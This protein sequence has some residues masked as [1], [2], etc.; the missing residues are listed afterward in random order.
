MAA[1]RVGRANELAAA[2]SGPVV[3]LAAPAQIAAELDLERWLAKGMTAGDL[4]GFIDAYLARAIHLPHP[5]ALAHQVAVPNVG[6]AVADLVHGAINNPMAIY[7]MGPGAATVEL[8]VTNWMLTHIGW[9]PQP[10]DGSGDG[11]HGGG[12]LTHGGSLANLTALLAARAAAAPQAWDSGTPHDLIVLAPPSSHY[13]IARAASILGLGSRAI[14]PLFTDDRDVLV[15]EAVAE[16]IDAA[17]ADGR[18]PLAVVVNAPSTATGLHDPVRA[19]AEICRERGVWL[20]VDAAHGAA[21]LL[22]SRERAH[23]DGID[24][25][26][27]VTWDAHKMLRTSGL[28]A[29]VLFR[30]TRSFDIAFRQEASYLFYGEPDFGLDLI[31]RTVECTKA[32]LGLKVYLALALDGEAALAA[33]VEDRYAAT[34]RFAEQIATRPG[35]EVAYSPESNILCFRYGRDDD[36]QVALRRRLL[37]TG[38][39][40]LS[41]ATIAGS[42]YL[43][44]TV[45]SPQTSEDDIAAVLDEITDTAVP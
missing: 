3:D 39:F 12:V 31:T 21:A 11:R 42:R 10:L 27:S 40:H 4:A 36:L 25:A 14:W 26:D 33:Y 41:S 20:H 16:A 19:V 43:R 22:S 28:C 37:R 1:E 30:D 34:R 2:G 18:R 17:C 5:R 44:M 7:E 8:A 15:A 29:A 38:S 45:M 24:L 9:R 23:L 35:F 13:S 6:A 32:G